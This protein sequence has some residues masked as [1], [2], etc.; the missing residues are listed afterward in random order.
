MIPLAANRQVIAVRFPELAA[1]LSLHAGA[2]AVPLSGSP[3]HPEVFEEVAS[4]PRVL[5]ALPGL[6]P[7]DP[8]LR[9]QAEAS[10]AALFWVVERSAQELATKL[11]RDDY[12]AWL[13]DPRVF[14][15]VGPPSTRALQ[16]LNLEFAWI[17]SARALTLSPQGDPRSPEW[18][19]LIQA[20][21]ARILQRWQNI[22]SSLRLGPV[23]FENTCLNLPSFLAAPSA[24]LLA[25]AFAGTTLILVGAGPSLDDA[26]PFLRAVAPRTIVVTGNTSFRALAAQGVA[27]HFT[28]TVDPFPATDL[29]Y[30]NQDLSQTHLVAPVF[31]YPAVHRR[32]TGRTFGL[33]DH[34][35]L[36][37][38]LRTAARLRPPPAILGDDTVSATI[39][40]LAAF[41]GCARVVFVGQDFAI[42]E[43][44]RTHASD[45]F[46][47][48]LGCNR[49]KDDQLHRLPGNT[50]EAVPVPIRHLYYLRTIERQVSALQTIRFLN[51]SHRGAAIKG[52]PFV[53]YETAA[54][55][56]ANQPLRD[57]ATEINALHG[58]PPP[59][60][61]RSAIQAELA[62][63][64][65][66]AE[67]ALQLSLSAA[68]AAE[69]A[70]AD[71]TRAN[72][73][74]FET[75]ASAFDRWRNGPPADQ[76]LLFSGQTNDEVFKAEKRRVGLPPSANRPLQEANERAWAFAE[77]SAFLH[78][79][80][81]TTVP[82]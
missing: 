29:G 41:L 26:L 17:D 20:T 53:A 48:D 51:T 43:D 37:A 39:L 6:P 3:F 58:Q 65:A 24:E 36:L 25:G 46:Y 55:E 40:N 18:E 22:K 81:G 63:A 19:P 71:P 21:L 13:R 8:A 50:R 82:R 67:K 68:L 14:I 4:Q 38:R 31:A 60:E 30:Q 61:V 10:R 77:G 72:R 9:M 73:K 66:A 69:I 35:P 52:A 2:P 28:V 42:A 34:S 70:L 1:E 44:G 49:Q 54:R 45:T 62:H 12:S 5:F 76:D 59:T 7:I 74:R 16:R 75:A 32:F 64:R 23:Q 27:P 33:W 11:A 80:L 47:S 15:S 78:R 56:L 57:F 79:T